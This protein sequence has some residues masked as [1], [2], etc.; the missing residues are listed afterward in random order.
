MPRSINL[1]NNAKPDYRRGVVIVKA[2][3]E[4]HNKRIV[5]T[6]NSSEGAIEMF[7]HDP[8]R[9]AILKGMFA[10]ALKLRDSLT[11]RGPERY[12]S[13]SGIAALVG[14]KEFS[15]IIN[16]IG[17]IYLG[18]HNE[19]EMRSKTVLYKKHAYKIYV[20][21]AELEM[22]DTMERDRKHGIK[23][24][25]KWFK[26]LKKKQ[27]ARIT[28]KQISDLSNWLQH[29]KANYH[30]RLE[31]AIKPVLFEATIR[32]LTKNPITISVNERVPDRLFIDAPVTF[33][34]D[35]E[36]AYR[37]LTTKAKH[38]LEMKQL[39]SVFSH[40]GL[41]VWY[42]HPKIDRK[43]HP[44]SVAILA[45]LDESEITK[46]SFFETIYNVVL[47]SRNWSRITLAFLRRRH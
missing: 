12:E 8:D 41:G 22:P 27:S 17:T 25:K 40:P 42:V 47:G 24:M 7:L 9:S 4:Y 26:E 11:Y 3:S 31:Q 10:K 30:F 39:K 23:I 19:G 18:I 2:L 46:M 36:N 28:K 43:K 21:K 33:E 1:K 5:E 14:Q 16:I 34:A 45:G 37:L 15:A 35:K 32:G 6:Q 29:E 44:L 20:Y 38:D 13:S